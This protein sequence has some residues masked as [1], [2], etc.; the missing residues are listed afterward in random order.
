M[1]TGLERRPAENIL[2][3]VSLHEH[4]ETNVTKGG[5]IETQ[6]PVCS[7]LVTYLSGQDQI[8]TS[9]RYTYGC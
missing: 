5:G 3:M 1:R 6:P 7:T 8:M 2:S 4:G 9:S